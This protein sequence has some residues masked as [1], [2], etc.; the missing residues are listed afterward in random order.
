MLRALLLCCLAFPAGVAR[1]E[2]LPHQS[3]VRIGR[4]QRPVPIR[5]TAEETGARITAGNARASGVVPVP[6]PTSAVVE[7]VELAGGGAVAVVRVEGNGV[8]GAALIGGGARPEVLWTGRLDATGDLGE[9]HRDVIEIGDRDGDRAPDVV[10][11]I[12]S[13]ATTICGQRETLLVP[14]AVDPRTL[15]LRDVALRRLPEGVDEIPVVATLASPG[16]SGE[17]LLPA[18]HFRTASSSAGSPDEPGLVP[19]PVSLSDGSAATAW[20]EGRPGPGRWE[21]ATAAFA[22]GDHRVRALAFT[23]PAADAGAV[24]KELWVVPDGGSRL[25]VTFPAPIATPGAKLW[26]TPPAPMNATCISIVLDEA[27][28]GSGPTAIAEVQAYTDL[29]FGEGLSALIEDVVADSERGTDAA[30]LLATLGEPAVRAVREAWETLTP[31]G[32]RRSIRVFA[33]NARVLEA[34]REG[35][36]TAARDEDEDVRTD[37]LAALADTGESAIDAIA[38]LV[39]D[40][41]AGDDAAIELAR[42]H[43]AAAA[44]TILEALERD[45]GSERR[46]LRRALATA[47]ARGGAESR[48]TI[49]RWIESG[50]PIAAAASAALALAREPT[51]REAASA[52]LARSVEQAE[53]FEDRWRAVLAAK[54]TAGAEPVAGGDAAAEAVDAWLASMA[55]DAEEW[56][57]RAAALDALATRGA[58]RATEVAREALDDSYPRVRVAAL[59]VLA[60]D[61]AMVERI[62]VAARRDGWPMV[63]AKAVA[64]LA[65]DP[66]ALPV[67]RAAVEDRSKAVRAAAIR[68]LTEARDRESIARVAARLE[69]GEE[70]AEVWSAAIAYARALCVPELVEP[71]VEVLRRGMRPNAWA[72]DV[73]VAVEA[74]HALSLLGGEDA[75]EALDRAASDL[76]P[77]AIRAAAHQARRTVQNC[78]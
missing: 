47:A 56:M 12:M 75:D 76:A 40:P 58:S 32:R 35:L 3:T 23:M 54:A 46:A 67:V 64:A 22:G 55:Q 2:P 63:R 66:R 17:P 6:S 45:G 26:V 8:R 43:P 34:A 70:F 1:A 78:R 57:L 19:P 72:T 74:V 68:A 41:R 50:P 69:D 61:D 36:V 62:A 59:E 14:R 24:P 44:A 18:L 51:T 21:F 60:D 31:T 52:L 77:P 30:R 48:A 33:E 49:E 9:R 16:P 73:E 28:A 25:R 5:V 10:V 53:R 15:T 65:D 71:I 13:E 11:G 42:R 7:R 29:D 20:R 38:A 39:S 4:P 37:A 27:G